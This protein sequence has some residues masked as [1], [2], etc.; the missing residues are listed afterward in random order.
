MSF[1]DFDPFSP[2]CGFKVLY[3][4]TSCQAAF[5]K[6]GEAVFNWHP[7]SVGRGI[8]NPYQIDEP[9]GRPPPYQMWV[10]R[11]I[12][13]KQY[14]YGKMDFLC[15]LKDEN[16]S[17]RKLVYTDDIWMQ[18]TAAAGS[19]CEIEGRSISNNFAYYNYSNNFCNIWN[20]HTAIGD[21]SALSNNLDII[22]CDSSEK[23]KESP[24]E[25]CAKY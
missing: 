20:L 24:K 11:T 1:P 7:K 17:T 12:S 23:T 3:P 2:F 18:F 6:V 22:G 4:T 25:I 19:G 5:A 9:T 16:C 21:D 8:Y 13:P 15:G 10:K 14:V